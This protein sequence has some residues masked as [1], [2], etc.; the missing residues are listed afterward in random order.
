MIDEM[1]DV[2]SKHRAGFGKP[3]INIPSKMIHKNSDNNPNKK[4]VNF[5]VEFSHAIKVL[6]TWLVRM[7]S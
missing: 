1:N 4:I 2:I 3:T 6:C 7:K 5:G